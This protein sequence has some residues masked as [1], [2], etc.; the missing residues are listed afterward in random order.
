ML[1]SKQRAILRSE[2][3]KIESI[4]QVGKGGVSDA[5]SSTLCDALE[6]RELIKLSVLENSP[7]EIRLVADQLSEST[8]AE[9]VACIGRKIILYKESSK[10][11]NKKYSLLI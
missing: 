9:V 11:K 4:F 6:A 2:A 3:T 7:D 10:E 5:I 8:G 1:N